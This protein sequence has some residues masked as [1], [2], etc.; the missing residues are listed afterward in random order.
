VGTARRRQEPVR[1]Q[2][3]AER[4]ARDQREDRAGC[5]ADALDQEAI[6]KRLLELDGS[7]NKKNLGA[8]ALLGVSLA[9]RARGGGVSPACRCS[10]TWR[11]AGEHAAVPMM[12][13]INGG[14]HS[15]RRSISRS[16]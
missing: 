6:D 1:R 5:G 16:S 13:V 12:N 14:A 7:K 4:G 10:V 3:S 15:T 2:R 11:L 9:K 8:N